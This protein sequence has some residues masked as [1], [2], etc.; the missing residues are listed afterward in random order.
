MNTPSAFVVVKSG[1]VYRSGSRTD[2][3]MTPRPKDVSADLQEAGLSVWRDLEAAINLD[4]K[5]QKIDLSKLDPSIL[6]CFQDQHGH[7]SIVPLDADGKLDMIKLAEW[8]ATRDSAAPHPFTK[9]I[10]DAVVERNVRR[11]K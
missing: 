8:A 2:L 5:A 7:V 6:G 1:F 10:I 4:G 11:P 9:M 3:T